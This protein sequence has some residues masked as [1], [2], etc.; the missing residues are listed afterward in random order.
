[1]EYRFIW[2]K[3]GSIWQKYIVYRSSVIFRSRFWTR[4]T[5]IFVGFVDRRSI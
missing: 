2:N 3:Y 5:F 1:M 4:L